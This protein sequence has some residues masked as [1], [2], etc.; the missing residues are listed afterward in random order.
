MPAKSGYFKKLFDFKLNA[1][2]QTARLSDSILDVGCGTGEC[3]VRLLNRGYKV[4]G[5]DF[6]ERFIQEAE[7]KIKSKIF[8]H[9]S[10]NLYTN[11]LFHS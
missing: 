6:V 7:E 4:D 1:V 9:Y 3:M 5:L 10:P 8:S 2:R 11:Y